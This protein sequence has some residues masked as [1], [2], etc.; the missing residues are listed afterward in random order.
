M[1]KISQFPNLPISKSLCFTILLLIAVSGQAQQPLHY[2]FRHISQSEGLLHN[3]VLSI[4]QDGKGFIWIATPNGLQRY[5]G[6]GF[7]NY[8]ELLSNSFEG[9][10]YGA[11]LYADKKNDLL[12]ISNNTSIEKL[13]LNKNHFTV[14]DKESFTENA[15][16][17][18][19][20]KGIDSTQWLLAEDA[21]Y[22][23]NKVKKKN[24]LY[25]IKLQHANPRYASFSATDSLSGNT[26]LSGASQLSFLNKNNKRVYS[27]KDNPDHHPLLE[28]LS[29][30]LTRYIM[31]DSH[32]DI[33]VS[34]W[35]DVLFRYDNKT[36]KIHS[37]Y[38]S[39]IKKKEEGNK[40]SDG[41][42]LINCMME[43]D[44]AVIWAGTEYGGL[45][46]YD[47]DNDLFDYTI[48]QDK[49]SESIRYDYK[50]FSLFQDREQNIWVGTDR[51]ISIFN[52]YR[53]YFRTTRHEDNNPLS[54]SKSEINCFIQTTNADIFI[55]TWGGGIAVYDKHF[56]FKKNIYPGLNPGLD[57][58]PNPGPPSDVYNY[59]WSFLQV[60]DKTLW[61]GCQRGY[62]LI[63]DLL[64]GHIRSLSPPEV[65]GST[66]RCMEKDNWGNI[67]LGL[68]NGKIIKWDVVQQQFIPFKG[69]QPDSLKHLPL[70][71]N[72]FIDR[73]QQFWI[74][75]ESGLKQFDPD[76]L[77]YTNTW[78]PDKN[79][80]TSIS[81]RTC[82]GIEELNDS[83]I[84]IGTNYGGLNFFN[85]K[86][87]RFTHLTEADGLPSNTIYAIKK[88]TEGFVWFTTDY[89]LYKLNP[90]DKSI[91]PYN[92]GSGIINSS[93]SSTKFYSLQDGE[94]LTY[95]GTEAISFYPGK[96]DYDNNSR[97][98]I[99]ITGFKLFDKPLFIDSLLFENK[100]VRLSY[101][102]NFFT[103]EFA[104]LNFSRQQQT[105]YY[106]RLHGID[107]D[108]VNG[109]TKRF[110]N[111]TDLQPGKYLFEVKAEN[112]NG[113]VT[114]FSIII[115]P[116]FWKTT[117][118]RLLI[119]VLL[120]LT[121][122]WIV[123][124][125]INSVRKDAKQKML[126]NRQMAEMEMKAL[127][128]QM[129]P[130]FIFNCINSIDALIQSNDKYHATVYLNKFAKLIRNIL[131]SSK[132][133]TVTLAK[134]LDTLKLYIELEQLRHENKFIASVTAEDGLLQDDY[135][136]P[137]LIVQPFVE[138]AILHGLRYRNDN[139][140]RLSISVIR[141]QDFLKYVIEDNGVGRQ[142]SNTSLQKEKISYGIDMSND[143]VKLFNN[144]EKAS[145]QIIDLV[146]N[147]Q[148]A[149]TRVQVL[150][151]IQ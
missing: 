35:G 93:F 24:T 129:N 135:K 18:E 123:K 33:W 47:R 91:V 69:M 63:Y 67:W 60:D 4:A 61:I 121:L 43:D 36:K 139:N 72:I 25:C 21:V 44:N 105:N 82:Q 76:R 83:I 98:R 117:W 127:R 113:P 102:E 133:N 84:M 13:E 99:E 71:L 77:I 88:D 5:D 70:V 66:I 87:K 37:Y 74:S 6:A 86:T 26:W 112:G 148:P 56:T 11:E 124:W 73:S 17:I 1:K 40:K 41:T 96:T 110:A 122:Y 64:T 90:A 149:G 42:L 81:G 107:K 94:W 85:K 68:Q 145:V 128:S 92:T 95:T 137:P 2:F 101:K 151:K 54:I 38:L 136:V 143:R 80:A 7:V 134:D 109:G 106:Y 142:Q 51:G 39:A 28:Q 65:G 48:A 100:P 15:R 116:P 75:T 19:V 144:E 30:G 150:L 132:Q 146:D 46:R 22:L 23:Y 104:A 14:K 27:Y 52:P 32:Q 130:H 3:Q 31:I 140:G 16:D 10:T 138:N 108:W 62:L 120:L 8:T 29:Y 103:I 111:Y 89:G 147:G 59:T 20:Y 126:F 115:S 12:W 78:L 55:G 34:T 97:Q 125:R 57:P 79:D 45:L 118:F 9:L 114:S 49:S 53:Q 50:I 141:Q 131:D 58:G 119:A